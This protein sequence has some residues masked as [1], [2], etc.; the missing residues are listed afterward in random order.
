MIN[1]ISVKVPA[2]SA[3]KNAGKPLSTNKLNPKLFKIWK[4]TAHKK[5]YSSAITQTI[6]QQRKQKLLE[7]NSYGIIRK[8]LQKLEY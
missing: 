3:P 4:N 5:L 2:N 8:P 1:S 6:F 7:L